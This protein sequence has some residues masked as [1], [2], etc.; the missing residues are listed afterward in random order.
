MT[1]TISMNSNISKSTPHCNVKSLTL[2]R[3]M[4][5]TQDRLLPLKKQKNEN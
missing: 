5:F 1:T 3:Q 4:T 2:K